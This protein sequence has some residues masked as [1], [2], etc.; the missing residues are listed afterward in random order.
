MNTATIEV[1]VHVTEQQRAVLAGQSGDI[2]SK[3]ETL[4]QEAVEQYELEQKI[5]ALLPEVIRSTAEANAAIDDAIAYC[6][7]SDEQIKK[8]EAE[9]W[10]GEQA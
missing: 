4:I 6:K 1:P 2:R 5:E 7:A 10:D 9:H 3:I 8:M